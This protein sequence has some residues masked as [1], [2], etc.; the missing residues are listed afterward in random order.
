MHYF[1]LKHSDLQRNR[2]RRDLVKKTT[3]LIFK[4]QYRQAEQMMT[5][6]L[7]ILI[8]LLCGVA[9]LDASPVTSID[10]PL[11]AALA[12]IPYKYVVAFGDSL[13]DSIL[14][15]GIFQRTKSCRMMNMRVV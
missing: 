11:E 7:T 9:V 13:T 14:F 5:R 3:R 15:L 6:H 2:E 8:S 4:D 10:Q 12:N 1:F